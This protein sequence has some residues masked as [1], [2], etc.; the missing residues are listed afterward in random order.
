MRSTKKKAIEKDG[1]VYTGG[2]LYKKESLEKFKRYQQQ[3]I[4]DTYRRFTIRLRLEDDKEMIEYVS[5][6]DSFNDYIRKLIEADMEK[7]EKKSKKK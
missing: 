4:K 1:V 7:Q 5:S 6:K 2:R 3:Y